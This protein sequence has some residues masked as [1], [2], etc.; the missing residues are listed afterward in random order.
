MMRVIPPGSSS[1]SSSSSSSHQPI[2][3]RAKAVLV[4]IVIGIIGVKVISGGSFGDVFATIVLAPIFGTGLGAYAGFFVGFGALAGFFS[5][6]FLP[7]IALAGML[8]ALA[9]A[10]TAWL[11]RVFE[12]KSKLGKSF[13][14]TLFS[15]E[16]W[17]A[18]GV[19]FLC[20]LLVGAVV[21]YG[22]AAGFSSIGVFDAG[23]TTS[24]TMLP[25]VLAG[26][27]GS[28]FEVDPFNWIM[29]LFAMLAAVLVAGG[30]IGGCT[31]GIVGAIVGAGFSSIG[32][33]AVIAGAAEG[34][35]FRFFAPY[36]PK[37]L[38]SSWLIHLLVGAGTGAVESTVI[39]A[40]VGIVLSIAAILGVGG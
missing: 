30:I 34:I 18:D 24:G 12:L 23:A 14:S 38:R 5:G 15:P 32:T 27:G 28:G 16:V 11:M 19:G 20:K 4:L 6:S 36:R 3:T 13:V 35:A 25:L 22:V 31:G 7:P 37:D 2:S 26:G 21:G 17:I 40:G 10:V 39:G 1:S 33:N 29:V 8:G 9:G